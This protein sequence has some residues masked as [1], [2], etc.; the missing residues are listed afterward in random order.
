[1]PIN[2]M[3]LIT[4]IKL[5]VKERGVEEI[6]KSTFLGLLCDYGAFEEESNE[7][8]IKHILKLWLGNGKMEKI[9]RMSSSDSLWKIDVSD[10]I[11]QTELEGFKKEV[12]SDLLH[13]L[14]ISLGIVDSSFN[15]DMEF[16]PNGKTKKEHTANNLRIAM[17]KDKV[18]VA[19][20]IIDYWNKNGILSRILNIS[21]SEQ[22]KTEVLGVLQQTESKGYDRSVALEMIRQIIVGEGVVN[23]TFDWDKEFVV[24]VP[25]ST[26]QQTTR[27]QHKSE[28]ESYI[29]EAPQKQ[30]IDNEWAKIQRQQQREKRIVE[31]TKVRQRRKAEKAVLNTAIQNVRSRYSLSVEEE[32][33]FQKY[34]T[35]RKLWAKVF[36]GITIAMTTLLVISVIVYCYCRITGSGN[37]TLWGTLSMISLGSG[38]LSSIMGALV[39]AQF[40]EDY[41]L[42]HTFMGIAGTMAVV[43]IVSLVVMFVGWI[44]GSGH[45]PEWNILALVSLCMGIVSFVF[46]VVFGGFE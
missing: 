29:K 25:Q 15:W 44:L 22:W 31:R 11:H 42:G 13:K 14:L 30:K 40:D 16:L 4:C 43:L 36:W 8:A 7:A 46:G 45:K 33:A 20:S 17:P 28:V 18:G 23:S 10:I 39:I 37:E 9:S 32:E 21:A 5:I 38:A 26:K 27:E 2:K 41:T 12:A 34:E 19:Q 24:S 1:M 6:A 35:K 3:D